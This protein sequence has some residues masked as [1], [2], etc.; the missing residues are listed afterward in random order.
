LLISLRVTWVHLLE[1]TRVASLRYILPNV[2]QPLR[3]LINFA[4]TLA[5]ATLKVSRVIGKTVGI[6]RK[7]LWRTLSNRMCAL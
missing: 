1:E 6:R 5:A 3:V 7:F 2:H 4:V